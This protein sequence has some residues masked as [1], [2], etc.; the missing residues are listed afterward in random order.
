MPGAVAR[1]LRTQP[2]FMY[3]SHDRSR[4][5]GSSKSGTLTLR[6][7]QD[8]L[9]F[10]CILPD[11]EEGRSAAELVRRGDYGGMSFGFSVPKGGERW[12]NRGKPHRE[13]TDLD[14][15]HI[16][17]VDQPAYSIG[18]EVKVRCADPYSLQRAILRLRF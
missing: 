1:S 4:L 7:S 6:D 18:T 11:T 5:L 15:H 13:L 16:S 3:A 8:G 14:L 17:L 12:S 10:E 9:D 2:V